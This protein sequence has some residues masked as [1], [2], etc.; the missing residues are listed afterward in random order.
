MN[1]LQESAGS[2]FIL[3]GEHFIVHGGVPALSFPILSKKTF[4]E[5]SIK[6]TSKFSLS[7]KSY[8]LSDEK[9]ISQPLVAKAMEKAIHLI[10]KEFDAVDF[11]RNKTLQVVSKSQIP[12]S[13]GFGSSASFSVAL[14]K[15][16]AATLG[17][18]ITRKELEKHVMTLE[19]L[20]H[21]NPSG[22]DA[23]TVLSETPI[24]F[25]NGKVTRK[26]NN[27]AVDFIILDS[28]DRKGCAEL[29]TKVSKRRDE[30]KKEWLQFA[31][32]LKD[33]VDECETALDRGDYATVAKAVTENH[34]ILQE[35]NLSTPEINSIISTAK[36]HGALAGKV[37]GAG[38]GGAV[39]IVCKKGEAH[40][41]ADSLK[42]KNYKILAV[43]E[44]F[45]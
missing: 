10:I 41:V 40:R 18:S 11:F 26:L 42:E 31:D 43:E 27:S 37:S 8:F 30:N 29:V 21:G 1:S 15:A 23:A 4:V 3:M 34:G 6:E 33:L 5:Q 44:S 16:T 2:K 13:R 24:R 36:K 17:Q 12:V 35:L 22:V 14:S 39:V 28:G 9:E 45:S 7:C 25:E 38:A 19:K 32:A 20:F